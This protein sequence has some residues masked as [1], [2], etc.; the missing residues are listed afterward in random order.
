MRRILAHEMHFSGWTVAMRDV[1]AKAAQL[2]IG[3]GA[4]SVW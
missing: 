2:M 4:R 1:C 3:N